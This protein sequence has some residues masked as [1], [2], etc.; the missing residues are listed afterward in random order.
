M[1]QLQKKLSSFV[2]KG[3]NN[4]NL[5]SKY[6]IDSNKYIS[7]KANSGNYASVSC[8]RRC[9]SNISGSI[10]FPIYSKI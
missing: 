8:D 9:D 5:D 4:S 10:P 2:S 1:S 7:L 6:C 3:T